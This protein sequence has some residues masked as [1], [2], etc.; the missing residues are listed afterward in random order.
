M[1]IKKNVAQTQKKKKMKG[2]YKL[3]REID[4]AVTEVNP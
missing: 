2:M 1:S 3:K 4:P